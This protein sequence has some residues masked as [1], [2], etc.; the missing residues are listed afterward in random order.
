[1]QHILRC[2]GEELGQELAHT[3]DDT[4]SATLSRIAAGMMQAGRQQ[5]ALGVKVGG[6]GLRRIQDIAVAA[7]LAFKVMARPKVEE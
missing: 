6:L 2:Y 3:A 7:S 1:M 5:A 4:I